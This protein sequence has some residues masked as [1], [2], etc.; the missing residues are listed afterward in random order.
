M[1]L[2]YELAE[3]NSIDKELQF[4]SQQQILNVM[5]QV[6]KIIQKVHSLHVFHFD[7]KPDNIYYCKETDK[8][9]VLDF[10]SS[11]YLPT[12]GQF[13]NCCLTEKSMR[14]T[15]V[16]EKTKAFSPDFNV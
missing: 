14:F 1:L 12:Q 6:C 10:G 3:G 8:V 9:T 2:E 13:Y 5:L 15:Q 7:I 11:Q 4:A 16:I